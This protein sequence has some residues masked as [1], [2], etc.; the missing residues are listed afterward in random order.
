MKEV[1]AILSANAHQLDTSELCGKKSGKTLGTN[2]SSMFNL[3]HRRNEE[4][5]RCNQTDIN[6]S[7]V[8]KDMH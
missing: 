5:R 1:Q 3:V 7:Y 6:F 2:Q 8:A 4:Y